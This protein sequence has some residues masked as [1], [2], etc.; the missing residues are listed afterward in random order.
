MIVCSQRRVDSNF[1]WCAALYPCAAWFLERS[2]LRDLLVGRAKLGFVLAISVWLRSCAIT[3]FV[4]GVASLMPM[5]R[6]LRPGVLPL[7]LQ[8]VSRAMSLHCTGHWHI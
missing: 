3:L 2:L 7:D 1:I 5:K 4:D 6:G 8:A